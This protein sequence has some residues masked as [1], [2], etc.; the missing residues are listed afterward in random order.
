MKTG[1]HLISRSAFALMELLVV[2]ALITILAALALPALSRT[3]VSARSIACRSNLRQI[4]L[5][6]NDY[7]C[8]FDAY[9]LYAS[10]KATPADPLNGLWDHALLPYCGR[11]R[12]LFECPAWTWKDAW[13][14]GVPTSLPV[15]YSV[16]GFNFCYGYN[17]FGTRPP[18]L[19]AGLGLGGLDYPNTHPVRAS[20]VRQPSDLI[21][22][23]DYRGLM[24]Y[25]A[26]G[27]MNPWVYV[28]DQSADYLRSR[29]P[30]GAN[31]T[32]CDSHVESLG[33]KRRWPLSGAD[34]EY[35]KRWNNDN[36][37]HPETWP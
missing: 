3:Q 8:D 10:A 37:P 26:N 9:P 14:D 6:L 4:A 23:G 30:H 22:V 24:V 35:A 7:L 2:T 27:L 34:S 32:F 19:D 33:R 31:V 17:A 28:D 13:G 18:P 29:H 1:T 11:N 15:D 5:A 21:A 20:F 25:Q 12:K 36:Q 16:N